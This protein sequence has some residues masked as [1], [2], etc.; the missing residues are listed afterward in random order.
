METKRNKARLKM[1]ATYLEYEAQ[2]QQWARERSYYHDCHKPFPLCGKNASREKVWMA[3]KK[4]LA[5]FP[6][7]SFNE[8]HERIGGDREVLWSFGL[9][10]SP[11]DPYWT[12]S[13][14]KWRV[15]GRLQLFPNEI[16]YALL[17]TDLWA[18]KLLVPV[19]AVEKYISEILEDIGKGVVW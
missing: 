17:Y 16:E 14:E 4:L 5:V 2:Y 13:I 1:A 6:K 8:A 11:H 3:A 12:E 19:E 9:W 18:E 7:V 15:Y 10:K